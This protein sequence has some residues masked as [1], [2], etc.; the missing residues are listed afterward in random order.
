MTSINTN[1]IKDYL[2]LKS[3]INSDDYIVG[4]VTSESQKRILLKEENSKRVFALTQTMRILKIK[5]NKE[6]NS[7]FELIESYF[8]DSQSVQVKD[9]EFFKTTQEAMSWLF[10]SKN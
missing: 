2:N 8:T 3:K 6:F 10:G 5:D 4:F 1:I 7:F 9:I